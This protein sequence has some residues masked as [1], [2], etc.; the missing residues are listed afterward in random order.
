[1]ARLNVVA[2]LTVI[3]MVA[4]MQMHSTDAQKTHYVGGSAGWIIPSSPSAYSTWAASQTFKVG[5]TLGNFF[6][7]KHTRTKFFT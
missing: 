3:V 6:L 7:V 1:M 4:A 2:F 5:D